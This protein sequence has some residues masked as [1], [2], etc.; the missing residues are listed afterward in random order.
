MRGEESLV[1]TGCSSE[2]FGH[3]GDCRT[4]DALADVPVPVHP[5]E[6]RTRCD[7]G[8]TH[9]LIECSNRAKPDVSCK[10]DQNALVQTFLIRFRTREKNVNALL[11]APDVLD[12]D[13]GN[14]GAPERTAPT[15]QDD[16][17]V[18][19]VDQPLVRK[20]FEGRT[21]GIASERLFGRGG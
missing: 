19:L 20:P 3:R 14:L 16:G 18:A 12:V 11:L 5:P 9:P 1:Q 2:A 4:G 7:A 10:P 15:E 6:D 21:Q 17:S 13:G 8:R